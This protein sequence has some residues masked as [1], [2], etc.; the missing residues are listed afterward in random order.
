MS[1]NLDEGN[2]DNHF[3]CPVVAYYPELLTANN[4]RG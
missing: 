4:P 1:Y 2:S 3:N